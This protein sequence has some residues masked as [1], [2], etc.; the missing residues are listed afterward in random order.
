[1]NAKSKMILAGLVAGAGLVIAC[2]S[3][4]TKANGPGTA[5]LPIVGQSAPTAAEQTAQAKAEAAAKV[6]PD[7]NAIE[8]DGIFAVGSQVKPGTYRTVVPADSFGCYYERLKGATGEFTDII[9]NGN[10]KA[11]AQ[12]VVT[13]KASDK[14]FHVE[15]CGTWHLV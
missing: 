8:G 10:A 15:R 3:G 6:A 7:P 9:A 13:V 1:M 2:G 4:A 12:I 5:D 14:F 11:G